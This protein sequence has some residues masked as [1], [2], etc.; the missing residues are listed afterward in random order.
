[1]ADNIIGRCR[2]PVC[3]S[4]KASLRVSTRQLAYVLCNVCNL[5][6]FARSDNSDSRLR[7]LH[8]A[9]ESAAA[10]APAPE[11]VA[12]PTPKPAAKPAAPVPA[13]APAEIKTTPAP[14]EAAGLGWGIF[15]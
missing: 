11:P 8:L 10:P 4:D 5:Q 7:A 12:T 15:R 9:D 1:M 6:A 14:A 2:C 3:Q 13:P